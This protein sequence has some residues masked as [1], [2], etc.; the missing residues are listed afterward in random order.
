MVYFGYIY[1]NNKSKDSGGLIGSDF[2]WGK[3]GKFIN[4]LRVHRR[5]DPYRPYSKTDYFR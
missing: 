3:P 2:K 1:F 5:R 4:S